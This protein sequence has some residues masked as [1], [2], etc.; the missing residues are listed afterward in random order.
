MIVKE[1]IE[2]EIGTMVAG[3]VDEGIC[4][5]EFADRTTLSS[6]EKY[7]ERQYKTRISDKGSVHLVKLRE[8]LSAYFAGTLRDFSVPLVT[9][10]TPFQQLVWKELLK[11]PYGTTKSYL[12]QA[13]ASGG[14]DTVRAVARAN[15]MNRIAIVIPCHRVIGSDGSLTGY[16]GGL[17]RKKWLLDHE[18]KYTGLPV[19][20]KLF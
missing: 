1:A 19:D 15:G 20:M 13:L 8:E 6:E 14:A 2:T 9:P 11:I 7:L 16:G 3:A 18:R 5:L 17:A 12:E 4:L 10:G